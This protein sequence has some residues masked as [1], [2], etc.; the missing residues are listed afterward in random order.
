METD[1]TRQHGFYIKST[2]KKHEENLRNI[3]QKHINEQILPR[4]LPIFIQWSDKTFWTSSTF[5][6]LTQKNGKCTLAL[7]CIMFVLYMINCDRSPVWYVC[8]VCYSLSSLRV[9]CIIIW[10][11]NTLSGPH[12]FRFLKN[13]NSA[14]PFYPIL[15]T[16]HFIFAKNYFTRV[17]GGPRNLKFIKIISKNYFR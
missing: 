9:E 12:Y 3:R 7:L 15:I 16:Q 4:S 11:Y 17:P 1:E 10:K 8:F 13:M 14:H 6:F 2:K 5:F